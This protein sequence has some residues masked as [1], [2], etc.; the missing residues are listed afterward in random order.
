[1]QKF[2]GAAKW[3]LLALGYEIASR[4]PIAAAQ[5]WSAGVGFE[6]D[7]SRHRLW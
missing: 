5:K 3:L 4:T 2:L 1:M 6:L 7:T